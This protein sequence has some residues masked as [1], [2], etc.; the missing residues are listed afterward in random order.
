MPNTALSNSDDYLLPKR[1]RD[2]RLYTCSNVALPRTYIETL[3]D[4]VHQK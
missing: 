1:V 3:M 4:Q 2:G